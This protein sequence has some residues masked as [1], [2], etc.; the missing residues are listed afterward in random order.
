MAVS[1][2]SIQISTNATTVQFLM[3]VAHIQLFNLGLTEKV[4]SYTGLWNTAYCKMNNFWEL[5]ICIKAEGTQVV[6]S[7]F[8][9]LIR[10]SVWNFVGR[11]ELKC[12]LELC[13]C[14]DATYHVVP[15]RQSFT[16]TPRTLMGSRVIYSHHL[17]HPKIISACK[18]VHTF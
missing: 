10:I 16:N 12:T 17:Y 13:H 6:T 14:V 8:S 4:L 15:K 7:L 9:A 11:H 5:Q 18:L 2:K 1:R 3:K